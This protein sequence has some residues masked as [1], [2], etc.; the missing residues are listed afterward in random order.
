M[1]VQMNLFYTKL[2]TA[3]T[4]SKSNWSEL[5]LFQRCMLLFWYLVT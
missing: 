2:R 1:N 4:L 5:D 3:I